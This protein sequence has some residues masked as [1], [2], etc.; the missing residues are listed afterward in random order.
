MST[1]KSKYWTVTTTKVVRANNKTDA[2]LVA[3]TRKP[4][5]NAKVLT[6]FNDAERISAADAHY[7]VG[8]T[9]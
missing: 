6:S 9:V 8:E 4:A 7:F 5:A 2:I 1:N 3:T